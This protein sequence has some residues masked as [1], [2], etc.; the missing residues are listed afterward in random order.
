VQ[1]YFNIIKLTPVADVKI[2]KNLAEKFGKQSRRLLFKVQSVFAKLGLKH[3]LLRKTPIFPPKI[4][5]NR[6]KL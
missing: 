4:G 1:K 2:L 3:G 6:R 5:E